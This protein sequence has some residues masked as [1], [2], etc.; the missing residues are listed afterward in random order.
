M[1]HEIL[2][3][4]SGIPSPIWDQIRGGVEKSPETGLNAY[5]SPAERAMLEILGELADLHTRIR[6]GAAIVIRSHPSTICRAVGSRVSSKHLRDFIQKT[7]EVERAILHMDAKFVGAYNIVPLS[8]LVTEFQP[9]ARSLRWLDSVVTRLQ[10]KLTSGAAIMKICK[11]EMQTGYTDIRNLSQDLLI[12]AE[13]AWISSLS[14][15]LLFGRLP[16]QVAKDFMVEHDEQEGYS[17]S[18]DRMPFFVSERAA[19]AILEAGSSI[20]TLQRW[21]SHG[22]SEQSSGAAARALVSINYQEIMSL[23]VPIQPDAFEKTIAA[24]NRHISDTALSRILP[25]SMVF[26]LLGVIQ[27]FALLKS[28]E[29]AACLIR[30]ADEYLRTKL[31]QSR[32]AEQPVKKLGRMDGLS[33]SD[34][35]TA[36]ILKKSFSALAALMPGHEA[37]VLLIDKAATY[38]KLVSDTRCIPKVNTLLPNQAA[39]AIDLPAKSPLRMFL[40]LADTACYRDISAYVVSLRRAEARFNS[41]WQIT[42]HRRCRSSPTA[43]WQA[44]TPQARSLIRARDE[45]RHKSMRTHWATVSQTVYLLTALRGYFHGEVIPQSW[46]QLQRWLNWEDVDSSASTQ[47]EHPGTTMSQAR[48]PSQENDQHSVNFASDAKTFVGRQ[49]PRTMARAHRTYLASLR[50]ALLLEQTTYLATLNN[51]LTQIDHFAALFHRIATVWAA[52]DIQEADGTIDAFSDFSKEQTEI[53]AELEQT[54][55]TIKDLLRQLVDNIKAAEKEFSQDGVTT[56]IAGLGLSRGGEDEFVPWRARTIDRLI[57]K[58]DFLSGEGE[59][60]DHLLDVS[61][62]EWYD[63]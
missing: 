4:L 47:A 14:P 52:L 26:E 22:G 18:A 60:M 29:F 9:W 27:N 48:P 45:N 57:M 61:D 51:L 36:A 30:E 1:L 7:V 53:A 37:D 21:T 31:H 58:L 19:R 28:G 11:D 54:N 49:D 3:S 50:T 40:T 5:T 2:L 39:L 55:K 8:A 42:M 24:T 16:V 10:R 59:T 63:A 6:E 12:T 20:S 23:E 43:P 46:S 35:D 15:W 41:L 33:I 25:S 56:G 32:R 38:L 62:D 17:L 34:V 13:Q 44:G